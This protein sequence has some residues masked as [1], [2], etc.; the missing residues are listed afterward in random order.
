MPEH[1]HLLVH[2]RRPIYSIEAFRKSVKQPTAMGLLPMIR[3]ERPGLAAKLVVPGTD[4]YR[5]WQKGKGFDRN[6]FTP[7]AIYAAIDYLHANPVRR[8]LCST[9]LDYPWSSAPGLTMV[10]KTWGLQWIGVR[11]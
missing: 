5:F 9:E 1:V 2:P 8:G 11:W 3:K 10:A 4:S 6:F 7:Q